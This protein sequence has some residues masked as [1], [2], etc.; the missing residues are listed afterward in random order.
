VRQAGLLTAT[1]IVVLGASLSVRADS[2]AFSGISLF[3]SSVTVL[4]NGDLEVAE[5][6]SVNDAA[7]FYKRG[8]RRDL[9]TSPQERWD[10]RYVGAYRKDNGVRVKVTDVTEDGKPVNYQL[11]SGYSYSQLSIGPRNE[12]FDSGSHKFV[13]RYLVSYA[14][15]SRGDQDILYWNSDGHAHDAP[16]EESSLSVSLP[17]GVPSESIE[18]ETRVS[19]R[20]V[21]LPRRPETAL[22]RLNMG[23][24]S[25]VYRATNL[26]RNQSLIVAITWPSGYVHTSPL[27]KVWRDYSELTAPAVLFLYY[28]IA[29]L[30]IGPEPKPGTK[31]PRY[32]PP[33]G[34]SPAAAR[35]IAWG[36]TDGRSLAAVIA[37]LAV[38][39]CLRVESASGKY[40]LSRL[41]SDRATEAS[42][43]REELYTLQL[44]FEDA[45]VIELSGAMDQRNSAQNSRYIF[46]IHG[47]LQDQLGGKYF[48]RHN[49][50]LALGV[51]ATFAMAVPM[52][53]MARGPDAMGALFF[54]LWVLFCGLMLGMMI[55]L[56]LVG[57][58]QAA[59][60]TGKGWIKLLPAALAT[61]IFGTAI[62][63]MLEKLADGVSVAFSLTIVAFLVINLGW[64]PRFKRKSQLGREMAD[65]IAGFR[66]FLE[67]VEQDKLN[68]LNPMPDAPQEMDRLLPYAIALEVKEAW[69][70]HLAQTFFAT[71]TVVED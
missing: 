5:E 19:G 69:G 61:A 50:F 67:K 46:H 54:T 12:P 44:L 42:L 24:G 51:L 33:A 65:Q 28:L 31:I 52:A 15:I 58:V 43:A 26:G 6:I 64:G 66:D 53:I 13:I 63:Y 29:W 16:I 36:T 23:D 4:K 27:A 17:P 59:L 38:R 57:A 7:A 49:G 2:P 62:V 37:Q 9:P 32:E 55:Q 30:W 39:G 1:F 14:L 70:D 22:D 35:F 40:K 21:G 34:I 41:M 71:T 45:P 18:I 56:S 10:P 8:F 11:G 20:G 48:T 47:E 3:R 68:R 60:K 25:I